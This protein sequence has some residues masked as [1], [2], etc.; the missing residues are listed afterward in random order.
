MASSIKTVFLAGVIIASPAIAHDWYDKGC[1]D[2]RDC[3]P[4]QGRVVSTPK[5]YLVERL[6]ELVPYGSKKIRRSQDKR[7]HT[8]E[9]PYTYDQSTIR[10]LYVPGGDA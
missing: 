5:G 4:E 10:C 1:C 6:G 7:F 8:C 2:D 9:Y 3:H